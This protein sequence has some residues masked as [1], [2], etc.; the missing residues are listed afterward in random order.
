MIKINIK[1]ICLILFSCLVTS[2]INLLGM[3]ESDDSDSSKERR[4]RREDRERER[5]IAP[6]WR[7]SLDSTSSSE[8]EYS[9]AKRDRDRRRRGP[10]MFWSPSLDTSSDEDENFRYPIVRDKKPIR[11]KV[12]EKIGKIGEWDFS[13]TRI[14]TKSRY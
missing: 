9:E 7:P 8:D 11:I 2:N 3:F 12:T 5:R 4:E 1:S 6:V 13:V 10:R 14:K